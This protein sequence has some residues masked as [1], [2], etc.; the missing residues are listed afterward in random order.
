MLALLDD[1]RAPRE[2][3]DAGVRPGLEPRAVGQAL[4]LDRRLVVNTGSAV[5]ALDSDDGS[6]LWE[7]AGMTPTDGGLWTDGRLALVAIRDGGGAQLAAADITDGRV[8]WTVPA[9]DGV[10]FYIQTGGRL[11]LVQLHTRI[12][13]GSASLDST[14]FG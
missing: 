2:G 11:Y 3:P 7:T 8:R 14:D 1:E 6:T 13:L 9:P 5:V 10:L 4:V 12:A